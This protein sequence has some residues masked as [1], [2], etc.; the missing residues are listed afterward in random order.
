MQS[1]QKESAYIQIEQLNK[2]FYPD[3]QE[4]KV[5]KGIDLNVRKGEIFGIIGFSG[6][7][8]SGDQ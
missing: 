2:S 5:L 8:K 7:G 4:L 6:A 3:G 1:D